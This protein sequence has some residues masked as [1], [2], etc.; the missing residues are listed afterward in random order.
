MDAQNLALLD[1][2]V[3]WQREKKLSANNNQLK[4]EWMVTKL[5]QLYIFKNPQ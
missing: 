4:P 3:D 5:S 2:G 1:L